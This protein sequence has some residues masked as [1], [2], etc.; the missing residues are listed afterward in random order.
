VVGVAAPRSPVDLGF[1]VVGAI[2]TR[3]HRLTKTYE[4]TSAPKAWPVP[5]SWG[6]ARRTSRRTLPGIRYRRHILGR[7]TLAWTKPT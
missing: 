1:E 7:Y 4:E 5:H 6:H 2:A 3:L